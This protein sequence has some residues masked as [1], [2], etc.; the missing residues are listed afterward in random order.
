VLKAACAQT[1]SLHELSVIALGELKKFKHDIH[2]VCGPI[3]TGGRGSIE[4]NLR[5]FDAVVTWLLE[6]GLPIFSQL[7]YEDQIFTLRQR[8]QAEDTARVGQYHEAIL[9]NFY[10]PL[11]QSGR[12]NRPWFIKGWQSS[13]GATWERQQFTDL[14]VKIVDLSETD[15][16]EI[17]G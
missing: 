11:I 17:L 6:A 3:T 7:P 9:H 5:V 2:L 14:K 8:W 10:A 16:D 15:I 4:E 13:T 12:I 1:Q